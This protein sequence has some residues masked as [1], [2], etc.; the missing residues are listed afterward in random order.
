MSQANVPILK[1]DSR[2]KPCLSM[3]A[4]TCLHLD[5]CAMLTFGRGEAR[6]V[7]SEKLFSPSAV[8]NTVEGYAERM[9]NEP[10]HMQEDPVHFSYS[11]GNTQ[12]RNFWGSA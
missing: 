11:G 7:R 10:T 6:K 5:V 9:E 4:R 12:M 3:K 1:G 8:A 2:F